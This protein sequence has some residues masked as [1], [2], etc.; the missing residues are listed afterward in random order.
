MTTHAVDQANHPR[1]ATPWL[2]LAAGTLFVVTPLLV[3]LVT[4]DA[5]A[6]M[7][8]AVLLL[9]A[10]LPGLR[11][12]QDGADGRAGSWGLR[13]TLSGLGVLAALVLTGDLVAAAVS[14]AVEQ[15]VSTAYVVVGAVAALATLLGI[16]LFSVGMT[17]ARVYPRPAIWVFL[18]GIVLGLV[19][20]MAEQSLRGPVPWLAD[21]L[22]PLGFVVAGLGL[23][24][25]GRAALAVPRP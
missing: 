24:A 9:V 21:V 13:L 5:F 18:G 17:R 7:G 19:S 10:A 16:V 20:E 2:T 25:L 3:E 23:L 6:L 15:V 1:G 8:V 12:R 14:G 4:G 11:R 22:P